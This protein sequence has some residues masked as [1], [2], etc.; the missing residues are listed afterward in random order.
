MEYGK[1]MEMLEC[2]RSTSDFVLGRLTNSFSRENQLLTATII[3][4]VEDS[5]KEL[6][7]VTVSYSQLLEHI[8][9]RPKGIYTN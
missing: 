5:T 6:G 8:K 4:C 7:A 9:A 1:Q 3:I 2:K